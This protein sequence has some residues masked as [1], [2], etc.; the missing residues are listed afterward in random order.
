MKGKKEGQVKYSL[1]PNVL[2]AA[3]LSPYGAPPQV[4]EMWKR[5]LF[6]SAGDSSFNDR[7]RSVL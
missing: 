1:R 4:L 2:L 3:L 5:S 7:D 6:S